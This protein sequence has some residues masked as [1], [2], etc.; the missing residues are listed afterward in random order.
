MPG[1]SLSVLFSLPHLMIQTIWGRGP[2]ILMKK[3]RLRDV[4]ECTQ[5]HTAQNG[6]AKLVICTSLSL[7]PSLWLV[8][9]ITQGKN[10]Q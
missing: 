5:G 8:R 6:R 9:V 10:P 7:N 1:T 2:Y 3:L 4:K